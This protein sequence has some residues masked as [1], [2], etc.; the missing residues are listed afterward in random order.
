[1]SKNRMR[2]WAGALTTSLTLIAMGAIGCA[3]AEEEGDS[4]ARLETYADLQQ[5]HEALNQLRQEHAELSAKIAAGVDGIEVPEGSE[6]T[7]E[8]ILAE[9]EAREEALANEITTSADAL[10]GRIVTFINEDPWVEGEEKTET[11]TGAVRMKS[12]E[13]LVLAMEFVEKGGDYKRATDIISR[14]LEI[15]PDNQELLDKLAWVEEMR[16]MS[17]DRFAAVEVGMTEEEVRAALGPPNLAN[18]RD[19]EGGRVGWYYPRGSNPNAD[20]A[21]GVFFQPERGV[22]TVYEADFD[23]IEPAATE[24]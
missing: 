19:Y 22:L 1:M 24:G 20:G 2:S 10:M 12:A 11:Q 15:D 5:E 3:P 9:L 18:V 14:A 6:Q 16:Y 21:A 17:E 8:E 23:A 13:D 7:A 4:E